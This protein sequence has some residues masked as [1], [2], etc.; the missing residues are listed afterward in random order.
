MH[1]YV[2]KTHLEVKATIQLKI[3]LLLAFGSTEAS[4]KVLFIQTL[5]NA[6][7]MFT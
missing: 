7:K 6:S 4:E 1:I 5:R 3:S 2:F